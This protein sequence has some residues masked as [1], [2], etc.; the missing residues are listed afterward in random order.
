MLAGLRKHAFGEAFALTRTLTTS[1]AAG[2]GSLQDKDRIFTNLY[3][4]HDYGIKGAMARG[5]W[6][7]YSAAHS[8]SRIA[9]TALEC[10]GCSFNVCCTRVSTYLRSGART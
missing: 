1:V 10:T 3:G 2:H 5:D 7:R 8:R 4:K 6:H 9:L